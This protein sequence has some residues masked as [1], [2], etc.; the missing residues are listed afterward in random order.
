[1][2]KIKYLGI[3]LTID[4]KYLYNENYKTLLKEIKEATNKWKDI[5][6][7]WIEDL[8]LLQYRCNLYQKINCILDRKI[9][10]TILKLIW[11]PKDSNKPMQ[12]G[13]RQANLEASHFLILKYIT[14]LE[15]T[16]QYD[17]GI[18]TDL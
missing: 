2:Q 15:W 5:P 16:K 18:K 3:N 1:M 6:Y 17:D 13:D 12:S 8:I 11:N 7:S 9:F 14:Q 10:K 4:L